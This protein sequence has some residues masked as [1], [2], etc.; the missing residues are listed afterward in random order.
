[1]SLR[2]TRCRQRQALAREIGWQRRAADADE[3]RRTTIDGRRQRVTA[4]LDLDR[5]RND[6]QRVDAERRLEARRQLHDQLLRRFHDNSDEL[7]ERQARRVAA[8]TEQRLNRN[9]EAN[10]RAAQ[11]AEK[12]A[13]HQ[14]GHI[15]S[16]YTFLKSAAWNPYCDEHCNTYVLVYDKNSFIL[17]ISSFN[18]SA[19]RVKIKA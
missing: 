9:I 18:W 16:R 10:Q 15:I 4:Q 2:L 19:L 17:C 11:T 7:G 5:T 6:E 1:M 13:R 14:V 3:A 8:L 12:Q